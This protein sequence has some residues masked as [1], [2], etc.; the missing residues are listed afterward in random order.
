MIRQLVLM[1]CLSLFFSLPVQAKDIDGQFAVFGAGSQSCENYLQAR[2]NGRGLT[3]YVNWMEAYLSAFNLIVP[4]TYN[5]AGNRS[6]EAMLKWT[7]GYCKDNP[8]DL[9]VNAVAALTV[10]LYP[11]RQNLSPGKDN[12][13]KWK[14]LKSSTD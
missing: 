1:V 6:L 10:A 8:Q 11:E 9:F 14:S 13:E 4:S 12:V 7:D 2:A 3:S 5:I